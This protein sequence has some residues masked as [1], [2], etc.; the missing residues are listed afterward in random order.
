MRH[1]LYLWVKKAD[2]KDHAALHDLG[3][4]TAS[5]VKEDGSWKVGNTVTMYPVTSPG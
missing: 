2:K 1:I 5:V 4:Y 3:S